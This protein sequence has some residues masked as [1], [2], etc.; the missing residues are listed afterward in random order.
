MLKK[1][2]FYLVAGLMAFVL[3]ACGDAEVSKV[4]GESKGKSEKQSDEK[5]AEAP[6]FYKPEESVSV[7]G[8][9]ISLNAIGWGKEAEYSESQNGNVLRVE[10]TV[11]NNSADNAFVDHTEFALSDK[12]GNMMEAYFGNDDANMF[13]SEIKKGKQVKG[14]LKYDVPESESYELFYEPSFTLKENAEV[15]WLIENGDIQ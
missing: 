2:S 5:A 1:F 13:S 7:D 8:V 4:D 15:K 6:E 12:D 9:E 3:G 11:M 10:V 14:V